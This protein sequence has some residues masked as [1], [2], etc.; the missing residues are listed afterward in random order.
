MKTLYLDLGMGAAGDMLTAALLELLP[1]TDCFI[2]KLNAVGIPSVQYIKEKSIK[3]GITGTHIH[4]LVNGEEEA[5]YHHGPER[6]HEHH[7]GSMD[8][9][10]HIVTGHLNLSEKIKEQILNI[11]KIIAEAES[12]VHDVPI[13]D[14]H[15]HE[16][17]SLD[18]LADITAVCMLINELLPDRIVASPVH[19]GSG[20]VHCAHGVLP[21]PAPATAEILKGIPSYGGSIR[22]ELCTPTGAALLKFFVDEFGNMPVMKV[23]R[24]GYGMGKKDFDTAN[25]V[26]AMLGESREQVRG[27]IK[28]SFNVDDMTAEE[29]G[30]ATDTLF[31]NGA[32]EVFTVPVGMKKNRPGTLICVLCQE[33]R[34]DEIVR[35]IFKYTTTIGIR[36]VKMQRYTLERE[37]KTTATGFGEVRQKYSYGYGAERVKIEYDDLTRIA[38]E[39]N[40]SLREARRLVE[41]EIND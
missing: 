8:E 3:C 37:I 33:E 25:C 32:N 18:A 29:I 11:Y 35:L 30:F 9:I 40:I 4:V 19:V 6:S 39:N 16:V 34:K 20:S 13:T 24:I 2:E 21:V 23:E 31:A 5:L 27:I 15:F 41:K 22:S 17:G 28:L 1:D 12:C 10:K 38:K 7:H 36:E 26:R 14:I